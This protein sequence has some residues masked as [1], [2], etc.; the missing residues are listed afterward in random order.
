MTDTEVEIEIE[1][2]P[3]E[4][5]PSAMFVHHPDGDAPHRVSHGALDCYATLRYLGAAQ[6]FRI[7]QQKIADRMGRSLRAVSGYVKELRDG[8]WLLVRPVYNGKGKAAAHYLVL[9]TPI[10][11]EQDPR[12]I[13]HQ[14][15]TAR[16][17]NTQDSA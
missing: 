10:V 8:G 2:A 14:A 5:I 7:R 3:F 13:K 1:R 11:D 4:M 17:Q 12:W 9:S 6:N 16:R 15:L